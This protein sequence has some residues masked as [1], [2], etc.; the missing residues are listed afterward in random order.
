MI[1]RAARNQD[2][3]AL[4]WWKVYQDLLPTQQK[5]V[6]LDDVCE[7]SGVT[8]DRLMAVVVSTAMRFGADVADF[9]ASAMLP[10]LVA[11]T[12]KSAMR[13]GGKYASVAQKDREFLFKHHKF[14]P[15]PKGTSVHVTAQAAAQAGAQSQPSVPTFS[16]SLMGA[17]E[18]HK[19]V[20][21]EMIEAHDAAEDE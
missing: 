12:G 15:V 4:A 10:N 20:Q 18:G 17:I 9:T 2:P 16:E 8:P 11:R 19:V 7:A 21:G 3:D 6:E 14:I 13:I 1:Q 5:A